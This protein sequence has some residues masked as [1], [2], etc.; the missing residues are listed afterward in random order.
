MLIFLSILTSYNFSS[1]K[2]HKNI[3]YKLPLEIKDLQ[4]NS[5]NC[6][7]I[8]FLTNVNRNV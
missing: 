2:I 5:D 8:N 6:Y 1:F 7:E 4:N 3:V